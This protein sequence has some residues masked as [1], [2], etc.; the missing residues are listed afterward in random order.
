M[1]EALIPPQLLP[2]LFSGQPQ[3]IKYIIGNGAGI[4]GIIRQQPAF[5]GFH[6]K[7]IPVKYLRA[8][9][10]QPQS[11]IVRPKLARHK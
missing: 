5:L 2:H 1:E 11:R 7:H 4:D 3:F 9:C 10:G 6:A 8:I